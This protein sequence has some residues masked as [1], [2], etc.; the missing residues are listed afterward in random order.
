MAGVDLVC[1]ASEVAGWVLCGL[2][3]YGAAL[4]CTQLILPLMM[5]L[6][7][8]LPLLLGLKQGIDGE[9]I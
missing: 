7:F 9:N 2:V 3:Q 1:L 4:T 6:G 8:S 5:L